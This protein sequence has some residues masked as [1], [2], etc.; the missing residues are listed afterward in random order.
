[1]PGPTG[2]APPDVRGR[3]PPTR[4]REKQ[5]RIGI[6]RL[7]ERPGP[8][9]VALE[10]LAGVLAERHEPGLSALALHAYGFGVVVER[11]EIERNELFGAQAAGIGQLEQGPV[12]QLE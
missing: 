4:L 12:A 2:Q 3:Q 6:C 8:R 7:E 5:R 10:R 1:M 9:Q 11:V